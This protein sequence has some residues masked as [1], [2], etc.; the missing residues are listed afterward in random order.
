M[1]T[2]FL[3]LLVPS[4]VVAVPLPKDAGEPPIEDAKGFIP[5]QKHAALP[6]KTIA[7]LVGEPDAVFQAEGRSGPPGQVGLGVGGVSYRWVYLP[8]DGKEMITNLSVELPN[9]KTRVYPKLNLATG[10]D[11]K[12][13]GVDVP[14]ALVEVNVNEG[15]GS[16]EGDAF[17]ATG[18]KR[19][20]GSKEF[21][22]VVPD[23]IKDVRAKYETDLSNRQ[24]DLDALIVEEAK[25]SLKGQEITG[26]REKNT[27]MY[28]TWLPEKEHLQVRFFSRVTDGAYKYGNG[29]NIEFAPAPPGPAPRLPNGLRYGSQVGV[30][31][32][33]QYEF[34][35]DGKLVS[36]R[37]LRA[38]AFA[39]ELPP[40]PVMDIRR[41]PPP[42]PVPVPK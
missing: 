17:V 23:I 22:L 27:L 19:V 9:G 26:P 39:K 24:K 30:E 33:M 42:L 15:A 3:L 31:A 40:P 36:T 10:G 2:L 13:L 11:M 16:P 34:A 8:T 4:L 5:F 35:K 6:G 1:R 21:S 29:I 20:D 41:R 18:I 37:E 25:R 7:V 28:M 12:R 32:G 14:Y 38:K